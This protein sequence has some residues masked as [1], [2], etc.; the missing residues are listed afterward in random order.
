MS[1]F[2]RREIVRRKVDR[3]S[4]SFQVVAGS[5]SWYRKGSLERSSRSAR[6]SKAVGREADEGRER[7]M[8]A[9]VRSRARVRPSPS[10]L[11][12]RFPSHDNSP[13]GPSSY[14]GNNN[15]SEESDTKRGS[16]S[17]AGNKD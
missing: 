10:R 16:S 13:E 9:R 17:G 15:V 3:N 11:H 2:E 5:R 6:S 7:R 8:D 1:G 12:R 14:S 4:P